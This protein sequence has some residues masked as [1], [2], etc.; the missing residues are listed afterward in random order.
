M[1]TRR[2]GAAHGRSRA[3]AA[4]PIPGGVSLASA[5][6]DPTEPRETAD[7]V[8]AHADRLAAV[9]KIAAGVAHEINN[10]AAFVIANTAVLTEHA[11]LLE[12]LFSTLREIADE[13]PAVRDDIEDL[14]AAHQVEAVLAD[15]RSIVAENT[16]GLSRITAIARDLGL[17]SRRQSEPARPLHANEIGNAACALVNTSV[18]HRATLVKELG[19][20]SLVLGDSGRLTQV[21]TNLLLNAAQATP[22]DAAGARRIF[23]RTYERDGEV[24]LSVRDEGRGIPSDQLDKI[25]DP[26]FTTKPK[27]DGTGLGLSL[28][29]EIVQEH[30]GRIDVESRLGHG[31]LVSVRIP[32]LALPEEV[33]APLAV[34]SEAPTATKNLRVLIIDD[35]PLVLRAYERSLGGSM[36]VVTAQTGDEAISV[37]ALDANFDVLL[38]DLMM[39]QSDGEAV[40]ERVRERWPHLERRFVFVSGGAFTPRARRFLER[41]DQPF[42]TKPV[43]APLLGR[44]IAEVTKH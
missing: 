12:G 6:R 30:G 18:R 31:T 43:P 21:L 17:F 8:R 1:R 42:L 14:L 26:F 15:I 32:A 7:D 38:C 25:F 34:I 13:H 37:L 11:D 33:A 20:T 27:G 40:Y 2:G 22:D 35:D 16:E 39:P 29:K 44:V 41:V 24:V 5:H 36:E 10:P 9:G 3:H 28:A 19:D 23:V 4:R